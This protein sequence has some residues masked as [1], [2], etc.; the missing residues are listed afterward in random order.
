[1]DHPDETEIL[2]YVS[3]S[4]SEEEVNQILEHLSTCMDCMER[5]AALRYLY[6]NF[7]SLWEAWTADEH[8]KAYNR[9]LLSRALMHIAGTMP[10]L[11]KRA[12]SWMRSLEEESGTSIRIFIDGAEGLAASAPFFIPRGFSLTRKP[13]VEGLSG[14]DWEILEEKLA[15]IGELF[16]LGRLDE[17]L[18]EL[19]EAAAVDAASTRSSML[20]IS[21]EG[22]LYVQVNVDSMER[23]ISVRC[24]P[25]E[26][27]G[28]PSL[29]L[30]LPGQEEEPPR[31]AALEWSSMSSC[32]SAE[33]QGITDGEYTLAI[34][35]SLPEF[36]IVL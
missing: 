2:R 11:S 34:G 29:V 17:A 7:D 4:A 28:L 32:F 30:L 13:E 21:L 22:K 33:F 10:D 19:K 3:E 6:R 14:S 9:W 5:V 12:L 35:P 18:V 31:G 15:R 26:G 8:G 1:M 20:Q 36:E 24:W 23:S 25:R 27:G 16:S